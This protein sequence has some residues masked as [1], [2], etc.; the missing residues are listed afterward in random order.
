MA[1][2]EKSALVMS[3]LGVT[4]QVTTEF[5]AGGLNKYADA[6]TPEDYVKADDRRRLR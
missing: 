4:S 2:L 1:H 5:L 6:W 3:Q